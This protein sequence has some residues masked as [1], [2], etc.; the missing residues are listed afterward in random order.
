MKGST[1]RRLVL[2]FALV[3]AL[4]AAQSGK[5]QLSLTDTGVTLIAQDATPREIL[6]EW[7]RV[8]GANIVGL[9]GLAGVP[10]TLRLENVSEREALD[11]VLRSIAGRMYVDRD[12]PAS[13]Q[14][15]FDRIVLVPAQAKPATAATASAR[16]PQVPAHAYQP[17]PNAAAG[18]VSVDEVFEQQNAA[19]EA[20]AGEALAD[21]AD[22]SAGEEEQGW[23]SSPTPVPAPESPVVGPDEEVAPPTST[24]FDYANPQ[25]YFEM[26]ARQM[27]ERLQAQ[28]E[29]GADTSQ[30][31]SVYVPSGQSSTSGVTVVG[32]NTGSSTS[33]QSTG[34]GGTSAVPRATPTPNQGMQGPG[35]QGP[36][37]QGQTPNTPYGLPSNVVPG[38]QAPPPGSPAYRGRYFNPYL[39]T[40]P[41][42]GQKPPS[43]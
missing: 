2:G 25:R 18:P 39:P 3:P 11:A 15:Q 24:D 35:T 41:Q 4:A 37:T 31:G 6:T 38:S 1:I 30:T 7:K 14:S 40:G 12:Q 21:V 5:V 28:G 10:L 20:E 9:E 32:G 8:T 42:A 22:G 33:T 36:G 19:A 17:D 29:G 26:R 16:S 23:G 27:Q 43:Q 34:P 13:G